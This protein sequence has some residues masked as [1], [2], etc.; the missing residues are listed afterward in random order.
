M[1]FG[2]MAWWQALLLLGAA[3]A[4]AVWLFRLKVRPPRVGVPTLFLWRRVLDEKREMTWWERVRRAVSLAATVL[5][6]VSLALAVTRP[7]PRRSA[8]ASRGRRL[9]VLDSSWSM[10]ART[11]AGGTRWDR[12]VRLA[13]RLAA[14]SGGADVALATTAEGLVEGPSADTALIETA[15]DRVQPSGGESAPWP[16]VAGVDAVHFITDGAVA[17]SL[18]SS[19]T[20]HSVFEAAPN[21]AITAFDARPAAAGAKA[22]EAFVAIANY[23]PAAQKVRLTITRDTSVIAE[24][25]VDLGPGEAGYQAFPIAS[26]KGGRLLARVSA[27]ENALAVD[28]EASAWLAGGEPIAVTVVTDDAASA[29][30]LL[31]QRW[32]SITPSFVAPAQF[33]QGRADVYIFDRW[34]PPSAPNRPALMIAPPPVDWLGTAGADEKAPQWIQPGQ[35][36]VLDGVDPLTLEIK[37]ARGLQGPALTPVAKSDKGTPLVA[38]ADA[39]DRRLVT[40][41]FALAESNLAYAPAFPVLIGNALEW[42]AQPSFGPSRRPGRVTL[43]AST[44]RVTDHTGTSVPL[45]RAGDFSVATLA[46]PGLHLVEAGGSRGVVAVNVGDPEVSNLGRSSLA[47]KTLPTDG[48]SGGGGRPWWTYAVI[49][50]FLLASIEWWTW[51]RRVTV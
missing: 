6:A 34:S 27:P 42:L 20:I 5:I 40:L 50:A 7:G 1:S 16:V 24:R 11:E 44:L 15:I 23:A 49:G 47:G 31:L 8:D 17:R 38:V 30:T 43:P 19:V 18:D 39:V 13:H 25:T 2:A 21:V 32:P 9:I 33:R 45:V 36:A 28:D 37:R 51:Q 46:T 48:A 4:V 41:S 35:H 3:A 26:G 22:P 29:L 10:L 12:A 14:S